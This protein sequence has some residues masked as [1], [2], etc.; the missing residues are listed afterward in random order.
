MSNPASSLWDAPYSPV[1][2][3]KYTSSTDTGWCMMLV[4]TGTSNILINMSTRENVRQRRSL[5]EPPQEGTKVV[6]RHSQIE[7]KK[8][9]RGE[10]TEIVCNG[11][12]S[13]R[14]IHWFPL[15]RPCLRGLGSGLSG[16]FDLIAAVQDNLDDDSEMRKMVLDE[17]KEEDNRITDAWKED[18]NSIVTFTGL[19]SAI[20]G[21]FIIEFYK[22]LSSASGDQKVALLQQISRQLPT[23][24]FPK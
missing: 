21:A 4:A 11:P 23:G 6:V 18:A 22:N 9:K 10:H 13:E 16:K 19:F 8:E 2:R 7:G 20:V 12:L 3:P 14:T 17:V 24:Q 1:S 15:L 5:Q